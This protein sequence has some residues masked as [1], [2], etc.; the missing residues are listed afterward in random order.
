MSHTYLPDVEKIIDALS[1]D[2]GVTI[3]GRL[4]LLGMMTDYITAVTRKLESEMA[5]QTGY[6]SC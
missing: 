3:E 4:I 1:V 6:Q 2:E 5:G